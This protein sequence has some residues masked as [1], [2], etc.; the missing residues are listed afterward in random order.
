MEQLHIATQ[1]TVPLERRLADGDRTV[2]D[3]IEDTAARTPN[4][5]AEEEQLKQC[6]EA[7]FDSLKP[8]EVTILRRRFGLETSK[9]QSL[10]EIGDGLGLSRERVRQIEKATL[11][12][13]RESPFMTQLSDFVTE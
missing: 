1:E 13:L 6:L 10:Q 5:A 12:R 9:P 3:L 7:C 11:K 8:R 2:A 4:A